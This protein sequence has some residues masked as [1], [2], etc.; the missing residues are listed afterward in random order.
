[1]ALDLNY[2]I[3]NAQKIFAKP[4]LTKADEKAINNIIETIDNELA[5]D[6][7][8]RYEIVQKEGA[9]IEEKR[10]E[11]VNN[12]FIEY[13]EKV[14]NAE[15]EFREALEKVKKEAEREREL[16][17]IECDKI[18][19]TTPYD[20][21]I[22][23]YKQAEEGLL[24]ARELSFK[25][26][27]NKYCSDPNAPMKCKDTGYKYVYHYSLAHGGD[28]SIIISA[29]SPKSIAYSSGLNMYNNDIISRFKFND[30]A[31]IRW[32]EVLEDLKTYPENYCEGYS[33]ESTPR[34][35]VKLLPKE[36][37]D[38][39]VKYIDLPRKKLP[40]AMYMYTG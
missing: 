1:M 16:K 35:G 38:I 2:L 21:E 19:L 7:A 25:T 9:E 12:A 23:L 34:F 33:K 5:F 4:E 3:G 27:E 40:F 32:A 24:S 26:F 17:Y 30:N 8:K 10:V 11:C 22:D 39:V 6:L 29:Y 18:K 15:E 13:H 36:A 20:K 37:C 31:S 28:D 14:S